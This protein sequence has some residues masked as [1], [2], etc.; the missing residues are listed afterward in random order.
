MEKDFTLIGLPVLVTVKGE[1]ERLRG[2][3]INVDPLT[4]TTLLLLKTEQE[5][6][7]CKRLE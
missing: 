5:V 2:R 4:H 7:N 1:S 3:L 6:S